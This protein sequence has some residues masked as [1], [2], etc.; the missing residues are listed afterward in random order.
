MGKK[1]LV[2]IVL[3]ILIIITYIYFHKGDERNENDDFN[4]DVHSTSFTMEERVKYRKGLEYI[5][6]NLKAGPGS[7]GF[8]T[9]F[10]K[11]R[12]NDLVLL[13]ISKEK[14]LKKECDIE[15]GPDLIDAEIKRMKS[16]YK[17]TRLLLEIANALDNNP[18]VVI[19]FWIKPI[20][21]DRYLR[22]CASSDDEFNY[23]V[24]QKIEGL[25]KE[26]E[27]D[28]LGLSSPHVTEVVTKL[29]NDQFEPEEIEVLSA[30]KTGEVTQVF[31]SYD[32]F[33]VFKLWGQDGDTLILK[34]L[35]ISKPDFEDWM[36]KNYK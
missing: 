18:M 36:K 1:R 11:Q 10:S 2:G 22:A 21:N 20:L 3:V 14:L 5:R 30:L 17:R 4:K 29:N 33:H 6:Y 15:I 13:D 31:E 16:D 26:F 32:D 35:S 28:D 12:I 7:P 9:V 24:R 25:V 23:E 34:K 27:S 8:E 19:E